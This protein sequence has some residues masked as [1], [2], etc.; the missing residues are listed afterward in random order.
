MTNENYLS[1]WRLGVTLA[2]LF[3]V[4]ALCQ[5]DRILPFILAESIK[6]DLG[7]NDT[8]LG[9]MTGVA[10][11]VCF[12]LMA[13]PL[14]RLADRGSPRLVLVCCILVWSAMTAFGG[15]AGSFLVLAI[16]RF[17][18]A[19]GEAGAVPA[20]HALI[21]R[22]IR[23]ESRGLAIGLFSMGIPL[24]TMVGF[25]VG[26]RV[27]DTLGWRMALFGAGAIGIAV[28]LLVLLLVRATP[29]VQK[30]ESQAEPFLKESLR[31][32]LSPVFRWLFVG[33]VVVG[34][35][36]APFYA[37]ATPFL[38]RVHG[39]SASEAGLSFGL[40]QGLM[41]IVGTLAGGRGFDR[42]VRQ[43]TSNLLWQPASLFLAAGGTTVFA[44][45]APLGWVTI[46]LFI[47]AMLS[48]SFLLPWA[49][50]VSHLVAGP[51]KQAMA[52]SLVLIG[53]S[54]IGP[55]LGPLLVGG[56]SDAVNAAQIP[57]GL[58]WGMLVVPLTSVITG[59]TLLAANRRLAVLEPPSPPY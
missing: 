32:L 38:I 30:T 54:L 23:P 14:A 8:Q 19:F 15:L 37:F 55:T 16:T 52:S 36:S 26:G 1:G 33:A 35:A 3:L 17:G 4:S 21:A 48:F 50:G 56:I 29:A 59:I 45:F 58:R 12:S 39:F 27:S 28:A 53:S 9:L 31:L 2:V 51:G 42:A 34:F 43:G 25:A 44:L 22:R 18:V 41:G 11:A 10:F 47:P 6:R 57:H 40:L 13:L 24:G 46:I 7:L 20:G 5:V 49:F